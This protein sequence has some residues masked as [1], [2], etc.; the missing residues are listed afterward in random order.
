MRMRD[1]TDYVV[2][3]CSVCSYIIILAYQSG[4]HAVH[5]TELQGLEESCVRTAE[6]FSP[7]DGSNWMRQL[8]AAYWYDLNEKQAALS[9]LSC[10]PSRMAQVCQVWE[11]EPEGID[12]KCIY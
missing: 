4:V 6:S 8:N 12:G 5:C 1:M 3:G 9:S 2:Y 11:R 10:S 7:V